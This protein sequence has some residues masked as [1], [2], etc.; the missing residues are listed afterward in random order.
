MKLVLLILV[1]GMVGCTTADND[2]IDQAIAER[3]YNRR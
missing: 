3:I 2:V 1:L